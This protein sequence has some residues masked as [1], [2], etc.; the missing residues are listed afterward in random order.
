MTY[1]AGGF[2]LAVLRGIMENSNS[3]TQKF[4][5]KFTTMRL[6]GL[7]YG[8]KMNE[9]KE[10]GQ[11]KKTL[12]ILMV[13]SLVMLMFQVG[14]AEDAPTIRVASLKGPTSMGL[15]KMIMDNEGNHD[16]DF[17]VAGSPDEIVP[18]L[19]KGE[20][21]V[22]LIPANLSSVLYNRLE[23]G[24]RMTAINTLGVLYVIENGDTV[25]SVADLKGKSLF[26][27]GK[28]TTP[29][30]A[31]NYVLTQNGLDPM[32]DLSIEYKSEAAEVAAAL[33]SGATKLA[34]LPQPLVTAALTQNP[35]LRVA[36]SL[37]D[38]WD[39]VSPDSALVTGVMI[40]TQDFADNA[41]EALKK[42]MD[43]YAASTA[44][45]NENPAEVS[46]KIEELGIAKAA[47]AEKAIPQC[48][49]VFITGDDMKQKAS[50]YLQTL[51][52][53]DPT[54]VGGKLPDEGFYKTVEQ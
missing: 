11:M 35:D 49:I 47:I 17:K 26:S 18:L 5:F 43:E 31:L 25:Q 29:E 40:A 21:D 39:K 2:Q 48:N 51:F 24:L 46:L 12:A 22:A 45:V 7:T 15:V 14:V 13:L 32:S 38:E 9:H 1:A 3:I 34:M 54:A 16:Y 27:T 19:A 41:P 42:F 6:T 53:Q 36:L 30:Y 52:E 44:F 50:G 33:G 4:H 23:G 10:V 20:L 8:Y 37:T 28:G